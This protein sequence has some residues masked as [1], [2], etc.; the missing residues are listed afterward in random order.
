VLVEPPGPVVPPRA[1]LTISAVDLLRAGA[2]AAALVLTVTSRGDALGVAVLLGVVAWRPVAAAAAGAALVAA[3][4]R[5]GSTSLEAIAGAQAVLG[6][7]GVVGPDRAAA[8][9]WLAAGA[10]VLASPGRRAEAGGGSARQAR[11]GAHNLVARLARGLPA[12]ASGAAAAVV[13][14]G[15]APG[16]DVWVRVVAAPVGVALAA[17]VA[18][19]RGRG[20]RSPW[21]ADG[22][23][24]AAGGAAL[25]ALGPEAPAWS[26]T[27]DTTVALHGAATAAAVGLL[28]VAGGSALAMGRAKR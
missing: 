7:A 26:G 6:P 8:A 25:V 4:W 27:V 9:C 24:L 14:A 21:V 22:L 16:G 18:A 3:S 10:I 1:G 17:A 23:A 28:V 11:A 15:P 20:G 5:W 12:A 19:V 2:A 13:V